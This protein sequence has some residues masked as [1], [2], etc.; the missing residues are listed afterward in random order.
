ME[1]HPTL[2]R[3][4]KRLG[5]DETHPP[6][7]EVWPELLTRINKAY[8]GADQERYVLERS[9]EISSNEMQ[10]LYESLKRSS[11]SALN[12]E[13]NKL[14]S[15]LTS[16][17]DSVFEID[18]QGHILY[19]N[20]AAE[21]ALKPWQTS[22]IGQHILS[23]IQLHV[24][25]SEHQLD[26][27]NLTQWLSWGEALRD[28]NAELKLP[29]GEVIPISCA[30]GPIITD[31]QI[32]GHVAV[33]RDMRLQKA[34]EDELR[35][36]KELAEDAA[37]TKASFLATMSHEIRTPLNGVIG[38]ATLLSDTRLDETQQHYVITL[39][40]S[41]EVLLS[42][43]NDILDFSKMDAGKVQLESTPFSLNVLLHD[44]DSMFHDQ[45]QQKGLKAYYQLDPQLPE[46]LLG[47]EHRL[48]Q[49]MINLIGNALKFTEQGGVFVRA[50]L[51]E[52]YDQDQSLIRFS[53]K[54]TG[55]GI[56]PAAQARLFEAFTQADSSTTRQ[57]GGTGL[58]LTISKKIVELM[59][60]HLQV[61]STEGKG[62]QFFFDIRLTKTDCPVTQA[63]SAAPISQA[64]PHDKYLLLVEDNKINQL[65]AG[66][67]LQKFGYQYDIAENGAQALE[68]IQTKA[69]DAIL[70][71]CQ[72][73]VLDGFE[74]TKRIRLLEQSSQRHVPIIGL[75]ANALEGDREK[76]LA[77]GMDD[78]TTKPIKIDEL[79]AKLKQWCF[80]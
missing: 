74:A 63:P 31:N 32:T 4:L 38:T 8:Q 23:F 37:A 5:V 20:S 15:V 14:L 47:D 76:C 13:K 1:L 65:V 79:E 10:K 56:S 60:G 61:T 26:Q 29:E 18:T 68:R 11:T 50:Q 52:Q 42:L 73:P 59:Q 49:V 53:V 78:F 80:N 70:M 30:L 43:I 44:L 57:F 41:A 22:P 58:G 45:F 36:A 3:Q 64:D 62:S 24:P 6:S 27:Q 9:L 12:Q 54:D 75:T 51:L 48:R 71:D 33:F 66:K 40:R 21:N 35:R 28:D 69:Y 25:F 67:F 17:T 2:K 7:A 34:A 55:I 39:K 16:L 46:W 19:L 72:M 77:C